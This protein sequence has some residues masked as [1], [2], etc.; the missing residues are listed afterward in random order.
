MPQRPARPLLIPLVATTLLATGCLT[1]SVHPLVGEDRALHDRR[2]VGDWRDSDGEHLRITWEPQG[3][4]FRVDAV[5][6]DGK[7]VLLRLTEIDGVAYVD[8]VVEPSGEDALPLHL[9][10]RAHV[11]EDR[12]VLDAGVAEWLSAPD[13]MGEDALPVT[14]IEGQSVLMATTTELRDAIARNQ[15]RPDFLLEDGEPDALV[16]TRLLPGELARR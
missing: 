5:G 6:E 1:R 7:D 10:L 11:T 2:L 4:R 3:R 16:L 14:K 15:W 13:L 9:L 8:A 12:V